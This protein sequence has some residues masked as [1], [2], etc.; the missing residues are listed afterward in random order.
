MISQKTYTTL[1]DE[2]KGLRSNFTLAKIDRLQIASLHFKEELPELWFKVI[3]GINPLMLDDLEAQIRV[4][5]RLA[6]LLDAT[7]DFP[8]SKLDDEIIPT[9]SLEKQDKERVTTLCREMRDIVLNSDNLDTAYR[10]RLLHRISQIEFE[11]YK[12]HGLYDVVLAGIVD[13]GDAFGK[14]GDRIKPLVDRI[15]E[16]R[17]ITQRNTKEYDQLPRPEEVKRLPKPID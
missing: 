11:I 2:V 7:K 16:I 5:D 17:G 4:C 14:F 9:F 3:N 10:K 15:N 1:S 6:S 12:P 13:A 8:N